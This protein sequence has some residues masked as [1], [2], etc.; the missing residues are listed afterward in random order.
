MVLARKT[1]TQH[2][3]DIVINNT[4]VKSVNCHNHLGLN[5]ETNVAWHAHLDEVASKAWKRINILRKLNFTL[6][7]Q[8]LQIMYFSFIRSILEYAD[9]V[10]DNFTGYEKDE[11]EKIQTEAG[12]IVTGATKSC[13]AAR[14]AVET[15][16]ERLSYRRYNHRIILF[17][18]MI[19]KMTPPYSQILVSS[20]YQDRSDRNLRNRSNIEIPIL[21]YNSFLPKTIREWNLLPESVKTN[22]SLHSLKS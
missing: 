2:H 3:A 22:R 20:R 21:Y 6:D 12:R 16:W 10:W 13:S 4:I 14:L 1:S 19:N 18:K 17:F 5:F 11:I 9:I 8:S 15:K 7:R